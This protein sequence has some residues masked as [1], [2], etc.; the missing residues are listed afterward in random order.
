M[1]NDLL[2]DHDL[3]VL[4]DIR[5]LALELA[6]NASLLYWDTQ[7]PNL[8]RGRFHS[9][10]KALADTSPYALE[11]FAPETRTRFSWDGQT[12]TSHVEAAE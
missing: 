8:I 9:A 10:L 2:S 4:R 11:T 7:Y 1:Q 12:V 6:D 3:T 5:R